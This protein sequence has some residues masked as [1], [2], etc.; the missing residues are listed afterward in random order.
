MNEK[1]KILK[2]KFELG[3]VQI[4]V[5]VRIIRKLR[6][7]VCFGRGGKMDSAHRICLFCLHL[8]ME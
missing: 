3:D 5:E 2:F 7:M 1:M 6:E 4:M 8:F